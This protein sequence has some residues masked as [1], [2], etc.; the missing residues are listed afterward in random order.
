MLDLNIKNVLEVK[1]KESGRYFINGHFFSVY[2][3]GLNKMGNPTYHLHL[4]SD[5]IDKIKSNK[6]RYIGRLYINTFRG[7]YL[8]FTSYNL[9]ETLKGISD[10]HGLGL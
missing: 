2:Y 8:S 1:E 5:M 4:E 6:R 9:G 3:R 7:S 10:F